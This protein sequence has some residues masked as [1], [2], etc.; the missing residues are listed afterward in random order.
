MPT[1][2]AAAIAAGRS[3][4]KVRPASLT[5]RTNSATVAYTAS[6]IAI[7]LAPPWTR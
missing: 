2:A 1:A 4:R 3:P 7:S 6:V 5:P